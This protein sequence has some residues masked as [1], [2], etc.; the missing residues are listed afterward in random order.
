LDRPVYVIARVDRLPDT[1]ALP[2]RAVGA[3]G[4][5]VFYRRYR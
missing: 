5:F 2:L 4:G 3:Q 1:T